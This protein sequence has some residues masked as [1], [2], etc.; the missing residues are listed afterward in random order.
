[1]HQKQPHSH[2]I[3]PRVLNLFL[4]KNDK[5]LKYELRLTEG[6]MKQEVG[7]GRRKGKKRKHRSLFE[8]IIT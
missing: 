4:D 3:A 2:T 8:L 1:M 5:N 6:K 7:I